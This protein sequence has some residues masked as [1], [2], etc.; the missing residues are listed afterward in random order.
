M[1]TL[2]GFLGWKE[3]NLAKTAQK[4]TQS[5]EGTAASALGEIQASSKQAINA[6]RT[7]VSNASKLSADLTKTT[8]QTKVQ[9]RNEA[10]AVRIQVERSKSE[11]DAAAKLQPEF[12]SLRSQLGQATNALAE[13]QKVISSSEDFVKKVFSTHAT[14]IFSF[15]EFVQPNAIVFPAPQGVKGSNTLVL[16]LVPD[17]PIDGT[18]QLQYK[19][20]LQPQLS[21]WHIHNLILLLWGDPAE[22]LKTDMLSVSYF[23]DKSDKETIKALTMRDGRA[24][25]DD[26]PLPKFGQPD[27]YWKGNKWMPLGQPAQPAKPGAVPQ[28]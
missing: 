24:Y 10:S 4:A 12:E 11:L 19:I 2:A 28:K 13:Q 1:L 3:F 16:M 27:P 15:K 26:Q 14:Y 17:T 25:A 20:F 22:N 23:P 21:Y 5:I 18:L 8:S 6:N 9:L 7:S